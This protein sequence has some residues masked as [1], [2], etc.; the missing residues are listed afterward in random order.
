MLGGPAASCSR[1][2]V[3][4]GSYA[5]SSGPKQ[6]GHAYR[7]PSSWRAPHSR[8][9]RAPA[10]PKAPARTAPAGESVGTRVDVLAAVTRLLLI[11]PAAALTAGRSWHQ[12][13]QERRQVA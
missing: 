9:A 13:R 10:L 8:Q 4:S 2:T 3:R 12:D 5:T 6:S 1:V 11:F 7:A